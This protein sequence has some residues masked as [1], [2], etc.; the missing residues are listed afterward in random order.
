[1]S[2]APC[3]VNRKR[4]QVRS[5]TTVT[6]KTMINRVARLKQLATELGWT[7]PTEKAVCGGRDLSSGH[8]GSHHPCVSTCHSLRRRWRPLERCPY[9]SF[10]SLDSGP[11]LALI[12]YVYLPT[13]VQCAMYRPMKLAYLPTYLPRYHWNRSQIS[14]TTHVRYSCYVHPPCAA[15]SR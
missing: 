6:S 1:M 2:V 3:H 8:I 10:R 5:W 7:Q 13:Y 12:G 15:H 4:V 11:P 14:I 9:L